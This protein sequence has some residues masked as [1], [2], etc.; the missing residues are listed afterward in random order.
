ME[1]YV[2]TISRQFGSMGRS[3]AQKLSEILDILTDIGSYEIVGEAG[4]PD[5]KKLA[6]L[7]MGKKGSCLV[8]LTLEENVISN[9]F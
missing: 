8:P 1:K 4:F 9:N 6:G 7:N 5:T 3:I 2:I